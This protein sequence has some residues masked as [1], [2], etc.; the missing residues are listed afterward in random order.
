MISKASQTLEASSSVKTAS[1]PNTPYNL[2]QEE[3]SKS[4]VIPQPQSNLGS[5]Q[6][7]FGL[8]FVQDLQE[9]FS[10]L[11][12][13]PAGTAGPPWGAS[14][15]AW[16]A[17]RFTPLSAHGALFQFDFEERLFVLAE[18]IDSALMLQE[19][20]DPSQWP[21]PVATS[22][23]LKDPLWSW[24]ATTHLLLKQISSGMCSTLT[25]D[26]SF[27]WSMHL[28]TALFQTST[29]L[30]LNLTG[31]RTP[32]TGGK[33][34]CLGKTQPSTSVLWVMQCLG[35][36]GELNTNLLRSGSLKDSGSQAVLFLE[37][38]HVLW[39]PTESW[40]S[41]VLKDILD[42]FSLFFFFGCCCLF[43]KIKNLVFLSSVF[44]MEFMMVGGA[45]CQCHL[46]R[47][48]WLSWL[49]AETGTFPGK[50]QPSPPRVY[51]VS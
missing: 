51:C 34:Q 29:V 25:K 19:E 27:S 3:K 45:S 5:S 50:S 6:P 39:R 8:L 20:L 37:S 31:V 26:S 21:S 40:K 38:W 1:L 48:C 17:F 13:C 12:R 22:L 36:Q 33:H 7:V 46:S 4:S 16:L 28:K 2:L 15:P 43:Y 41:L 49:V 11:L 30:R 24:G 23:S 10:P 18:F 44:S 47:V 35:L 32:S 9:R 42:Y 14:A